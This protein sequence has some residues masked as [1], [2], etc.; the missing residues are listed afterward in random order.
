MGTLQMLPQLRPNF[1]RLSISTH[2]ELSQLQLLQSSPQ[3]LLLLQLP[4]LFQHPFTMDSM[5]SHISTLMAVMVPYTHITP[6]ILMLVILMLVGDLLSLPQQLRK[7]N[8]PF[9]KKTFNAI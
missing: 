9:T 4:Q 1:K 2:P 8:K 3:L 5:D 7:P 6:D